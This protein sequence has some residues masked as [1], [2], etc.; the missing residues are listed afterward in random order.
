MLN[1]YTERL[2]CSKC[3]SGRIVFFGE[4]KGKGW[5]YRCEKCGHVS[6]TR[7]RLNLS[8]DDAR[9]VPFDNSKR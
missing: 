5:H 9:V 6:P 1:Q 3:Q 7:D 4:L 8:Q 2:V